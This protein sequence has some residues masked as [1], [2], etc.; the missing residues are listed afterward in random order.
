MHSSRA[1]VV[2]A[3]V[4]L[5]IAVPVIQA[6]QTADGS[7]DLSRKVQAL[8]T[9]FRSLQSRVDALERSMNA[10]GAVPQ[11]TGSTT[12]AVWR[13]LREGMS[14]SDVRRIL[15]EPDRLNGGASA[16]WIYANGGTV[17]FASGRVIIWS[18]PR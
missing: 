7:P 11:S 18:E 12:K 6:R 1:V 10:N 2:F 4:T 17:S 16:L 15:G 9:A 3:F 14:E 5:A 13:T 8:E